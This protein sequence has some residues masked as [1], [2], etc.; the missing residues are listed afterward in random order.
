MLSKTLKTTCYDFAKYYFVKNPF[1]SQ[2][3]NLGQAELKAAAQCRPSQMVKPNVQMKRSLKSN[4]HFARIVHQAPRSSGGSV[5]G[6][7]QS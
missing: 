7:R 3:N 4:E 2:F 1:I 5:R 6:S